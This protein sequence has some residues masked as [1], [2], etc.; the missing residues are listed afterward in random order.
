MDPMPGTSGTGGSVSHP[1]H[2]AKKGIEPREYIKANNLD[3]NEG[4]IVKYITRHEEKDGV[5]DIIKVISYARFVL[6]DSYNLTPDQVEDILI[7]Q[8]E[9]VR[10]RA[11]NHPSKQ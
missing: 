11:N 3:F 7:H 1:S 10:V 8:V 9:D 6:E 2:Y 4:N 5:G